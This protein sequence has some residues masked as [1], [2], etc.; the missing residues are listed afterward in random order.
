MTED[1]LTHAEAWASRGIGCNAT[2]TLKLVRYAR[3]L[4]AENLRLIGMVEE[5]SLKLEQE[6]R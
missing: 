4:K 1:D 3:D 2:E 6:S 5:L